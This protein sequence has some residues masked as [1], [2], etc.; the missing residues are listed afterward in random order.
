[1]E[2]S[3]I[4]L[5]ILFAYFGVLCLIGWF[6]GKKNSNDDFFR[7]GHRSPWFVVAFGMIGVSLSG[8]TFLSVSGSVVNSHFSYMEIVLGNMVGYWVMALVLP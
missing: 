7:A 6:T 5:V 8:V 4:G 3:L 1:M 2:K